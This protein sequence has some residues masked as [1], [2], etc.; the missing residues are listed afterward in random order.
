M[1]AAGPVAFG[2]REG[3]GNAGQEYFTML[4]SP[5]SKLPKHLLLSQLSSFVAAATRQ[6]MLP[7]P[8]HVMHPPAKQVHI[9]VRQPLLYYP[10]P[11]FNHTEQVLEPSNSLMRLLLDCVWALLFGCCSAAFKC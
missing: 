6:L 10:P 1:S 2:L 11:T 7:P 5:S 3:E 9:E 4:H 8:H